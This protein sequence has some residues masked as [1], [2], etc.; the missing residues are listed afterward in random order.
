MDKG[1]LRGSFKGVLYGSYKRSFEELYKGSEFRKIRG[2]LFGGPII[3]IL[4]S[5]VLH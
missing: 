3:R 4:L 2:T 1:Y 5:R